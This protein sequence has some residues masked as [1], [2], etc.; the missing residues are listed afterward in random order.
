MK[1]IVGKTESNL[2]NSFFILSG[3]WLWIHWCAGDGCDVFG[4]G[5]RILWTV[6]NIVDGEEYCIV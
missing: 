1:E 5:G 3:D 6:R 4:G 2:E